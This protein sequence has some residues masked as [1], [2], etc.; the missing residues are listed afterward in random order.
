MKVL[1]LQAEQQHVTILGWILILEHAILLL[2]AAFVWV[3]L[4]GIGAVTRDP[5]A[6]SILSLVATTL[7]LFLAALSIPGIVAGWALLVRK[8][9]SR[10]L[11]LAIAVL[12][13][14][15]IPLGTLIGIYAIFVLMQDSASGYFEQTARSKS[16]PRPVT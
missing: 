14:I 16:A 6:I 9:W 8:W 13:L 1:D 10:Y 11:A 3:L 15:N 12:G 2:V 7:A 5:E 4:T